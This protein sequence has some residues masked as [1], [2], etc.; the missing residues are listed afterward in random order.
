MTTGRNVHR[1]PKKQWTRWS[2]EA[3]RVFNAV[4]FVCYQSPWLLQHP[5]APKL[6]PAHAKTTAWNAAWLAADAV[7][8]TVPTE[9][10][11]VKAA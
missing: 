5:K 3:R 6:K 8:D 9:I 1:V 10:V 4:Y 11:T 7:D 2:K